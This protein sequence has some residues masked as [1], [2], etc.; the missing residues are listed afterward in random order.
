[1]GPQRAICEQIVEGK[2]DYV[3]ALK[4]NQP[5]FMKD[6]ELYFE[7]GILAHK[8]WE[9]SI[10]IDKAH[11]RRGQRETSVLSGLVVPSKRP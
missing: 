11:G 3:V 1:M 9:S 4:E 7:K 2:R 5:A 10:A 6:I 8:N